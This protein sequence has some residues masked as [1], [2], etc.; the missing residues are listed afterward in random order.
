MI[1]FDLDRAAMREQT[2]GLLTAVLMYRLGIN[3]I[4]IDADDIQAAMHTFGAKTLDLL[5]SPDFSEKTVSFK[6]VP[7]K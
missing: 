4:T 2:H 6:L 3:E 1:N 5:V 7:Q